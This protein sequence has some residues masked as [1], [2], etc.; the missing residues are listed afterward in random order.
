M[1]MSPQSS[2]YFSLTYACIRQISDLIRYAMRG[3]MPGNASTVQVTRH[4]F[5][6]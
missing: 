3:V 1:Q 4:Y 5:D 2:G 6:D